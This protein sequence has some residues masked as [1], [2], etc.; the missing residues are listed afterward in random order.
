M[1]FLTAFATFAAHVRHDGR[2]AVPLS[3]CGIDLDAMNALLRHGLARRGAMNIGT[4][5]LTPYGRG[6]AD[7][8]AAVDGAFNVA[9][10]LRDV[11]II[12]RPG[13][14]ITE[15]A[16]IAVL[17]VSDD[18]LRPAVRALW[19]EVVTLRAAKTPRRCCECDCALADDDE[20]E[21]AQ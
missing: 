16:D 6:Q 18:D 20:Q 4:Y 11:G 7:E 9:G 14:P 5:A 21:G 10:W 17:T 19:H 15:R 12:A 13:Q 2:A 8:L 3:D 1:D